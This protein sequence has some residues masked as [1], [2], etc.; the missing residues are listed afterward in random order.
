MTQVQG[1]ESRIAR[2][3]RDWSY[4]PAGVRAILTVSVMVMTCVGAPGTVRADVP[5]SKRLL[6]TADNVD[7]LY[8]MLGP[9]GALSY[10]ERE[11]QAT[12]GGQLLM[13]RVRERAALATLGMSLGGLRYTTSERGRAWAEVVVGTRV[14]TTHM[15]LG[16]GP[17]LEIDQ[18][19]PAR[20][21]GQVTAW[22]FLG[23]IPYVRAGYIDRRGSFLEAGI[24]V[25]LPLR[26]W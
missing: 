21:G 4:D 14:R 10:L 13:L 25:M 18:V 23:V 17:V 1:S 5:E 26:S 11:R 3:R 22:V 6:H 9:L 16:L 7:G 20:V 15:G 2:Q 19:A 8:L 24:Q 12:F